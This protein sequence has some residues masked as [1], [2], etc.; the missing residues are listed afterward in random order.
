MGTDNFHQVSRPITVTALTSGK[1]SPPGR[2]RIRQFIEPLKSHGI[3]VTEYYPLVNKYATKRL[4]PVS[5]LMRIPGVR[6]ARASTITWLERELLANRFSIEPFLGRRKI[7]D[8][9]DA[10]WLNKPRFSENIAACC[11]GVIAGNEFIASYYR[12][13]GVRVWTIPTSIDTTRWQPGEKNGNSGWT[14]GWTGSSSNLK[15]LYQIEEP[16]ASFLRDHPSARLLVVCDKEPHFKTIAPTSYMFAR[17]SADNEVQLVQSMD[18]G[19]MPLTDTEWER[20]KCALKMIMYMAVGIPCIISPVGVGK[21]ILNE[22]EVG[23]MAQTGEGWYQAL[24]RLYKDQKFCGNLGDRGRQL[25]EDRFSVHRNVR[26]L[27]DI[28]HVLVQ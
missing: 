15:Y 19:L 3:V 10:I 11:D 8:I 14:I 4:P 16:L 26:Q 2:F 23:L 27:A 20:G 6:A 24:E 17:W 18:V 28:F 22:A 21:S 9:D 13:K 1:N 5:M 7:V 12:S 25:V